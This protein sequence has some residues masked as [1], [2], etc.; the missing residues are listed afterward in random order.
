MSS[1]HKSCQQCSFFDARTN[2]IDNVGEEDAPIVFI[3]ESPGAVEQQQGRAF[4]GPAGAK[5][6]E[7]LDNAGL[8][9]K[10]ILVTNAA[11][12]WGGPDNKKKPTETD[13][14]TCRELF[15][16]KLIKKYPRKV[17][18]PMGNV[19]LYALYAKGKIS[20]QG[21][22]SKQGL[23]TDLPSLGCKVL[24]IYHPS[25]V[26]R[27]PHL[28]EATEQALT[29]L[30]VYIDSNY[31]ATQT[32]PKTDYIVARTV[33]DVRQMIEEFKSGQITAIDTETTS[34]DTFIPNFQVLCITG[35]SVLGKSWFFPISQEGFPYWSD[36]EW[37]LVYPLVKEYLEDSSYP[38]VLQN[39]KYD[40]KALWSLD[41]D[42]DGVTFDTM[43]AHHLLDE[44]SPHDLESLARRYLGFGDYD[45]ELR[46]E[47]AKVKKLKIP[48]EDKNYGALPFF[49]ILAPYACSDADA[50]RQ[51]YDVFIRLLEEQDLLSIYQRQ[52]VP[53]IDVL[54]RMERKGV[55]VDIDALDKM[56]QDLSMQIQSIVNEVNEIA[57]EAFQQYK[58]RILPDME[59]AK[60]RI[61]QIKQ[62]QA[63]LV[64][65][66]DIDALHHQDA[67]ARNNASPNTEALYNRTIKHW[68]E[69]ITKWEMALKASPPI[70]VGSPKQLSAFLF[71]WLDLK[72]VRYSSAGNP[73][74]DEKV[75]RKLQQRTKHPV[76]DLL[77]EYRRL[78]K[79]DSTYCV[80]L[81]KKADAN[82]LVHTDYLQHGTVTGRFSS[83]GPNLQNTPRKGGIRAFFVPA[84][85]HKFLY[86]DYGQA[87]VRAWAAYSGDQE[88]IKLLVEED[89]HAEIAIAVYGLENEREEFMHRLEL[90]K[91]DDWPSGSIKEASEMRVRA[92]AC[93]TSDTLIYTSE[94]IVP[95]GTLPFAEKEG[96]FLELDEDLYVQGDQGLTRV[97]HTYYGG[98][99]D[100]KRITTLNGYSFCATPDHAVQVFTPLGVYWKKV[101]ELEEGDWLFRPPFVQWP[102]QSILSVEQ[103][104]LAGLILGFGR[105]DES[106]EH[107][108]VFVPKGQ[109]HFLQGVQADIVKEPNGSSFEC[110]LYLLE[111]LGFTVQVR[112]KEDRRLRIMSCPLLQ[113]D[114]IAV[115]ACIST[116]ASASL[117]RIPGWGYTLLVCAEVNIISSLVAV[118]SNWGI[119]PGVVE[120]NDNTTSLF[121][122]DRDVK[123]MESHELV[124]LPLLPEAILCD[125]KREWDFVPYLQNFFARLD[126]TSVSK[127]VASALRQL[128]D[129][130]ITSRTDLTA[131]H[132]F[133]PLLTEVDRDFISKLYHGDHHY[134]LIVRVEDGGTQQVYDLTTEDHTFSSPF[135][136]NHNCVFGI[137]YGRGAASLAEEF[138][139]SVED[140]QDFIDRLFARFPVAAAWRNEILAKAEAGEVLVTATGRRR[141]LANIHSSDR[142]LREEALRQAINFPI[143]SLAA[144]LT[145]SALLRIARSLW[146]KGMRSEPVLQVH[147]SITVESPEEEVEECFDI[148]QTELL[149]PMPWFNVPL[150]AD[151]EILDYWK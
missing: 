138:G 133:A 135:F 88:L 80:G 45:A 86:S 91:S 19:A 84:K 148:M 137:M 25:Y 11:R 28:Q 26:L 149:R 41:I 95:I 116:L 118:L 6:W 100:T 48:V 49:E 23:M 79:R 130:N 103:A 113:M 65:S 16:M 5:F 83:R 94:G 20:S 42:L 127:G 141:R 14:L 78:H 75:L 92:K 12:C 144:D 85:G 124:I 111:Y 74:T 60:Q 58:A 47:F 70:K 136:V 39:A 56:H 119:Y 82:H 64:A 73:S 122:Y 54:A 43:L 110:D 143:Q 46:E 53:L 142:M 89:I 121:F 37:S 104:R 150:K 1:G 29:M 146:A 112:S 102:K 105:I 131:L 52:I 71:D 33:T 30:K 117:D 34:T 108:R 55:H 68:E 59:E 72:P 134:E 2:E 10:D 96:E 81:K 24:P 15:L 126:F 36:S 77:L 139:F 21:I 3:G 66:G 50:T 107:I 147:D 22:T 4:L 38:K 76:F 32:A 132:S 140:A 18:V 101:E 90:E 151:I 61:E 123:L 27:Q 115:K 114:E 109:R 106:G 9:T 87:E 67:V 120:N 145:N 99:K 35:S 7:M 31:T 125:N 93:V 13:L 129:K 8:D 57:G 98:Y 17:I 97:T 63:R 51:L 69:R 44:N 40:I 128:L 62:N